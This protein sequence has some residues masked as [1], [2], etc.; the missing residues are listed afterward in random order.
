MLH[1]PAH[2]VAS[3][4]SEDPAPSD[5]SFPTRSVG[6]RALLVLAAAMIFSQMDAVL[7]SLLIE[8]IKLE[9]RL[10]DVQLGFIQ[11]LGFGLG[12]GLGA[13]PLGML[14]DRKPRVWLLR[15]GL[16]AFVGAMT[17][18]ALA[19]G[20]LA[21]FAA[22]VTVGAVV[23]LMGPAASSLI[24]DFFPPSRRGTGLGFLA[25]AQLTG[26]AGAYLVGGLLLDLLMDRASGFLGISLPSAWRTTYLVF[27]ALS[28]TALPGLLALREPARM[29]TADHRPSIGRSFRHLLEY[30][31]LLVPLFAASTFGLIVSSAV[32]AWIATI[33]MRSYGL[34][35]GPV[36]EWLGF[37]T[38]IGGVLG[39]LMAGRAARLARC[40][41]R[42]ITLAAAVAC[43]LCTPFAF[44]GLT[45]SAPWVAAC[46]F[47]VVAT[48]ILTQV[49][50]SIAIVMM[51][52]NELRGLCIGIYC[53][54]GLGVGRGLAPSMVV[55]MSSAF[56]GPDALSL[57]LGLVGAPCSLIAAWLFLITGAREQLEAQSRRPDNREDHPR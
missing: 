50:S 2:F 20:F 30:R 5:A 16:V 49:T 34:R 18:A 21:L 36:G 1:V 19:K 24:S 27:A 14:I 6:H 23:A 9:L 12:Q 17:T 37:V 29:E 51:V 31:R 55:Y 32:Q 42:S 45:P 44:L 53:V 10:S 7:T 35:A 22:E 8:P 3:G 38:L 13:I 15:F 40:A 11:G 33:L 28:L 41:D 4:R 52:P 26:Q 43:T 57:G 47:A 39:S 25:T 48:T 46:Y 56:N 54:L